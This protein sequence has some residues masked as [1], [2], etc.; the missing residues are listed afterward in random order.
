MAN[1]Q[2]DYSGILF[3]NDD[4]DNEDANP[5]WPDLKGRCM[6]GGVEYWL[7]GWRKTGKQGGKFLSLSFKK[8]EPRAEKPAKPKEKP[9]EEEFEDDEMPF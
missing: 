1:E 7:S 4:K 3:T 8:M 9:P 2:R 5:N 6:V